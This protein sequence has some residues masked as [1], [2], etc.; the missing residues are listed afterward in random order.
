MRG[1]S[2]LLLGRRNPVAD[3]ARQELETTAIRTAL[4]AHPA[5]LLAFRHPDEDERVER[6]QVGL[7]IHGQRYRNNGDVICFHQGRDGPSFMALSEEAWEVLKEAELTALG[8]R[9]EQ[10]FVTVWESL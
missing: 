1:L 7:S 5:F 4:L 6:F 9:A 8:R 10:V 3:P 2:A